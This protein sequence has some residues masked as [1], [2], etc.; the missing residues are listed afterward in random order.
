MILEFP[1]E[2]V[3]VLVPEYHKMVPA[4]LLNRLNESLDE[5]NRLGMYQNHG[6]FGAVKQ[7]VTQIR[8]R[9]GPPL[10]PKSH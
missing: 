6:S 2:D 5:G 7:C 3:H 10:Q 8:D 1:A 9:C 4:F